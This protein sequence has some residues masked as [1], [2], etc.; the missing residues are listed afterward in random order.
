[1]YWFKALFAFLYKRDESNMDA[2]PWIAAMSLGLEFGSSCEQHLCSK[3]FCF[4]L[5]FDLV[6]KQIVPIKI[7]PDGTKAMN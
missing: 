7:S 1:M 3:P 2:Q 4:L 5:N 6:L